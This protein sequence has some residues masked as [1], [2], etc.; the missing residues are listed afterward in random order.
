[1]NLLQLLFRTSV[2]GLKRIC[3]KNVSVCV[4]YLFKEIPPSSQT[5][6]YISLHGFDSFVCTTNIESVS[7]YSPWEEL[8]VSLPDAQTASHI[9]PPDEELASICKAT[10]KHEPAARPSACRASTQGSCSLFY[11]DE[12]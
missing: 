11:W 4:F 10:I 1:M 3:C 5:T 9:L 12:T 7:S 8:V 6:Q 2:L